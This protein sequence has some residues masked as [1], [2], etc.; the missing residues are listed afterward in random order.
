MNDEL[1]KGA[2][3]RKLLFYIFRRRV[4]TGFLCGVAIKGILCEMVKYVL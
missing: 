1:K 3:L 2:F 4:F